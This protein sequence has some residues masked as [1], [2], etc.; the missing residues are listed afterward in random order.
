MYGPRIYSPTDHAWN[1]RVQQE[2]TRFNQGFMATVYLDCSK[3]YERVR[4]VQ[5][6]EAAKGSG[7][8]EQVVN[9]AFSMY[10]GKRH[11]TI[12]GCLV[13]PVEGFSG[14]IAGCGFAVFFLK[15]YL[16]DVGVGC[17]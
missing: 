8:P 4:H 5:A 13:D 3:C 7:C 17:R 6:A 14:L 10:A 15:T 16:I 1:T 2:L 12:H 9:L 11:I